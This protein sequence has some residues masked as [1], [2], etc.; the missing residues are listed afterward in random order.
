MKN[1]LIINGHH[2]KE[3]FNKEIIEAYKNGTKSQNAEIKEI[4]MSNSKLNFIGG[5]LNVDGNFEGNSNSDEIIVAQDLIKW[6]NHLIWVYPI[7]W[8]NMPA[9]LK[10]F[11]ENVFI[12]GFAFKYHKKEKGSYVKW[13]KLLKGKTS[14]IFA[15]M[16]TPPWFFKWL[17]K[18]PNYKT[19]KGILNFC[20]IKSIKRTYFGSVKMSTKEQRKK[21]LN[22]VEQIGKQLK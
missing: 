8:Y 20:G 10:S 18:D 15:T 11:I 3:S 6:A 7:W 19:M 9:K 13:D 21:W 2:R 1:I 17:N 22:K 12:S 14:R 4:E 16:D 5:D